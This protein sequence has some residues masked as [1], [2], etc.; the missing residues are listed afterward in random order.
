VSY[1]GSQREIGTW[2]HI[3]TQTVTVAPNHVTFVPIKVSIPGSVRPG[4]YQGAI[5]AVDLHP[6]TITQG[7]LHYRISFRRT[8][9]VVLRVLGRASAGLQIVRARLIAPGKRAVLTLTLKNTGTVIDHPITTLM[10]F[11]GP[12][13]TYTQRLLIGALTA[14][15]PT[16]VMFAI[17]RTIPPATYR[18]RMQ[19]TYLAHLSN[20]AAAQ[21]FRAEWTGTVTVPAGVGP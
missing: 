1:T 16:T 17:G 18:L 19:I 15:A 2:I 9:A 11:T 5:S 6:A 21:L 3:A 4:E 20:G 14:G 8:L 7:R 12:H 13:T 10:T